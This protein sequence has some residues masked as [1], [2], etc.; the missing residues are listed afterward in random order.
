[1][2]SVTQVERIG[3]RISSRHRRNLACLVGRRRDER[4]ARSGRRPS[5]NAPRCSSVRR[6]L[7]LN[8]RTPT[9]AATPTATDSTTNPNL[10][11]ADFRSRQP[12]AAARFQ[13]SARL[14]IAAPA[15][16]DWLQQ[17][18]R[19]AANGKR[20]FDD[21]SVLQHDLA[22]GA[23]GHF[24]IVRHQHQRGPR[25]AVPLEQQVEHQPSVRRSRG[26]PSARRPSQSAARPQTRAPAPRAAVRRRRAAPG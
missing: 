11:G 13:L 17:S 3:R 14:A 20:V 6:K 8:P 15:L 22:I 16:R 26:C 23:A 1:M 12:M 2:V 25:L 21:Q 24:G 9:S 4:C 19:A 5:A 7:S 10:P 18:A